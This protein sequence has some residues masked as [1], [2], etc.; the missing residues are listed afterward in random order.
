MGHERATIESTMRHE[1][2][3]RSIWWLVLGLTSFS[4]FAWFVNSYEPNSWQLFTIFFLLVFVASF[5]TFLY[6]FNNVRRSVLLSLGVTTYLLLRLANLR[7]PL[8]LVLLLASL[9][10]LELLL[11]K[12]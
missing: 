4:G 1:K 5:W 10:S 6:L 3:P 8:Y 7:E 2:R 12:R 9:T 11:S